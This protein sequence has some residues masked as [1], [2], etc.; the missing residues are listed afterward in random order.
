MSLRK[1][2]IAGGR[3]GQDAELR[4]DYAFI[5]FSVAT[6]R[7][8]RDP[9]TG[10]RNKQTEWTDCLLNYNPERHPDGPPLLQYLTKGTQVYI[11]GAVRTRVYIDRE[12][13]PQSK[14]QVS[15]EKLE[16]LGGGGSQGT[17]DSQQAPAQQEHRPAGTHGAS[18]QQTSSNQGDDLPF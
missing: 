17:A 9:E 8:T 2:I 16:L 15:V 12:Q 11:E 7:R 18:K 5:R 6:D 13:K 14:L 3:L 10:E 4:S 1:V